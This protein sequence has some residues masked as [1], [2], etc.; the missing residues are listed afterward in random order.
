MISQYPILS[1]STIDSDFDNECYE[2]PCCFGLFDYRHTIR[3]IEFSIDDNDGLEYIKSNTDKSEETQDINTEVFSSA[4][5]S[6]C[7]GYIT[8]CKRSLDS[9]K[10]IIITY[11]ESGN[12]DIPRTFLHGFIYMNYQEHNIIQ[13]THHKVGKQYIGYCL[14]E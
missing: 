10:S 14:Y 11:K 13:Y 7:N 12:V 8:V 4:I 1:N 3:D 2:T 5:I 9:S 6:E